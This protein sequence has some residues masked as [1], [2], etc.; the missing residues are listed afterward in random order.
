MPFIGNKPSAVPLTSADIT[1]NI[2][3]NADIN[4]SAAI[5]LSKL[6]TT[7]TMT[8]ASTIGVGGATPAASG[9]GVSFPATQ[10]ASTDANTLDDYEEGTWTPTLTSA[11]GSGMTFDSRG[12]YVKI[13][14]QVTVLFDIQLTAKGTASGALKLAGL[15]FTRDT[16]YVMGVSS[17][18]FFVGMTT[19]LVLLS[20]FIDSN[21]TTGTLSRTTAAATTTNSNLVVADFDGGNGRFATTVTY[22]TA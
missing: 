21:A 19:S 18:G 10:S 16:S 9:A 4:S 13:G 2:I 5:A 3:V 14:K 17:I 6:A 8:F 22:L 7:G 11:S 12:T 1:D 20:V 15:P